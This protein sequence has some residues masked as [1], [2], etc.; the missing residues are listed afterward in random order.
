MDEVVDPVQAESLARV[1]THGQPEGS[2][3]LPLESNGKRKIR[4]GFWAALTI[5]FGSLIVLIA[6]SGF[7]ALDRART[8][9][10][11]ISEAYQNNLVVAKD[12][13]DIRSQLQTSAILVRDYLLDRSAKPYN[14]S[15]ELLISLRRSV[16]EEVARL[17]SRIPA[18]DVP[19]LTRMKREVD[20][21]WASLDPIFKWTPEEK[22]ANSSEFVKTRVPRRAAIL[23]IVSQIESLNQQTLA[24]QRREVELR[25]QELPVFVRRSVV[26]TIL[27][28]FAIAGLSLYWI[29]RL[30]KT[31]RAAQLAIEKAGHELRRLS[32]QL[33][34]A[35][36]EERKRLSHELHDEV[37]QLLTAL[38]IELG[39]L[40]EAYRD[41]SGK[42]AGEA[43]TS[44]LAETKSLAEEA[45]RTVRDLAMGL[46]PAML[47]ELGLIPALEWQGREHSR[48][49]GIPVSLE[50]DGRLD[51]LPE[52]YRTCVY[53]VVQEALTNIAKHASA[54]QIL[55][56]VTAGNDGLSISVKDDGIGFD[57]RTRNRG[58]L[59][60]LGMAERVKKL[61]GDLEVISH[62]GQ[63]SSIMAKMPLKKGAADHE[64][65]LRIVGR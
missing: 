38:R 32:Q 35:Q 52:E 7:E 33:V 16:S 61:G 63:G 59:G 17:A 43:S 40:D 10:G 62:A 20:L 24:K 58:G 45:L 34:H 57:P 36:E 53:R 18:E 13:A 5:G 8:I 6:L 28:G 14:G 50:V 19:D 48:R 2:A 26:I 11:R 9:S 22:V 49:T 30:E 31:S 44:R 65:D 55:I 54:R 60:L 27:L 12:L 46:R 42:S 64:E 37:G 21:Y 51:E 29:N 15:P 1:R 47:D 25:Q 23:E 56:G 3:G 41:E 39:N 4:S